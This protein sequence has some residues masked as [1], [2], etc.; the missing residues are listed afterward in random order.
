MRHP[1]RF[2]RYANIRHPALDPSRR[3]D[4]LGNPTLL[5]SPFLL[6]VRLTRRLSVKE[7]N[8]AIDAIVVK[9][10]M[11]AIPVSGFISPGL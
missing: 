4:A 5:A 1:D 10:R 11:G 9:A 2:M 6:P 8:D 7:H 3:W